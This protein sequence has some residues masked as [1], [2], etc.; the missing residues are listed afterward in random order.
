MSQPLLHAVGVLPANMTRRISFTDDCW[1]WQGAVTSSGYGS[2]GHRGRIWST[3]RLAYELLIGPIPDGLQIDHLCRNKL[4]CNPWH[5]EPVTVQENRRRQHVA[6]YGQAMWSPVLSPDIL[7]PI[8][9]CA[10]SRDRTLDPLIKSQL[11]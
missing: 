9:T 8:L 10:P 1:N 11:M 6:R 4:C 3:H 5:L 2:V 7:A